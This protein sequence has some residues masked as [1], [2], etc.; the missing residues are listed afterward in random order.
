[1][2]THAHDAVGNRTSVAD[3]IDGTTT[4]D[5]D[6]NDRLVTVD[7][8]AGLTTFSY[9]A[10]GQ[11]IAV[12]GPTDEVLLGWN[13]DR[14]LE[15]VTSSDGSVTQHTYAPDGLLT[16]T[17]TAAGETRFVQVRY[18]PYAQIAATY[19]PDGTLVERSTLAPARLSTTDAGGVTRYLHGDHLSTTM[20]RSASDGS[21]LDRQHLGPYGQER[22]GGVGHFGFTGEYTDGSTGFVFLRQRWY[23][24][25]TGLM[26]SPDPFQGVLT[27]PAS[28]HDYQYVH[29]D[30][31]NLTDPSG[32]TSL[33]ESL[34]TAF[35][36]GLGIAAFG[37]RARCPGDGHRR[38]RKGEGPTYD[39]GAATKPGS[40]NT[41]PPPRH[42]TR[43]SLLQTSVQLDRVQTLYTSSIHLTA[44]V[45]GV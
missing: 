45:G 15:T 19:R 9:D 31:V 21:L 36:I 35:M 26:L 28:L 7:G 1:M 37:L 40:A 6:V 39:F 17:A 23:D 12:D 25:A 32:L 16:S 34:N 30:P 41:S 27:E 4:F 22:S 29:G 10:A 13:W 20:A 5:Y 11:R 38:H 2:V 43:V 18:S 42:R 33:A 3:S 14:R 8:P 44:M 24:P